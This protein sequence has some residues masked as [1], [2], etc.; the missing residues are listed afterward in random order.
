MENNKLKAYLSFSIR[1]GKIIFGFDNLVK[2]KRM[3][4]IV[5]ICSQQND[6]VTNKIIKFCNDNNL[7]Y[8]K[9]QNLILGELISR[10]NCKVVG[11]L[12]TSLAEAITKELESGNK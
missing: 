12:D 8:Y 9:L 4:I 6:K 10:P 3:P 7:K 5:I 11:I 2:S 1:S